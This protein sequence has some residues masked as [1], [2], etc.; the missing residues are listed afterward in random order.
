TSAGRTVT[1]PLDGSV[2]RIENEGKTGK[3]SATRSGAAVVVVAQGDNGRRTTTYR[4]KGD[5][6]VLS[7]E[8][9]SNKLSSPIALSASYLAR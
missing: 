5:Q 7:I 9:R 1:L 6:L 2:Q 4:R 3:M 8:M